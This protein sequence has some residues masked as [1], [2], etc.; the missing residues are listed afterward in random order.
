MQSTV[1]ST[2]FERY[3]LVTSPVFIGANLCLWVWG[4]N[5][6]RAENEARLQSA[7]EDSPASHLPQSRT[8]RLFSVSKNLGAHQKAVVDVP[9]VNVISRDRTRRA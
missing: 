2:G 6:M 1:G 4:R 9:R 8:A 3:G 7:V 5:T